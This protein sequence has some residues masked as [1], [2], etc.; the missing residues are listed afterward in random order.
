MRSQSL[1]INEYNI[2]LFLPRLGY[3]KRVDVFLLPLPE[4]IGSA[5]ILF[6]EKSMSER[7]DR[8]FNQRGSAR[9]ITGLASMLA[10]EIKNPLS[11]IRGAAQL[12]ENS[13]ND[14]DRQLTQLIQNETDRIVGL[15]DR[16]EIFSDE[17]PI[18]HSPINMHTVL[19]H[20]KMLAQNGFAKNIRFIEKYDPSLPP[21]SGHR[22]Q[23]IQIFLNLVKNASEALKN[24]ADATIILK[25][26]YKSGIWIASHN[27]REKVALPLEFCVEDNGSG[28]LAD[29]QPN[30]FDPF[31]TSKVNG[32]GLGL[33]MVAKL[34]HNHGGI[35]ECET[36]KGKTVFRV[37][38]PMWQKKRRQNPTSGE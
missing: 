6:H 21:V 38:L 17:R 31:I 34:V 9:S 29:I 20:V 36:Q 10:H 5:I 22:D 8:Q 2:D 37:L 3:N 4:K 23:L 18:E 26:S 14:E 24:H 12:I 33:P 19:N 7:M 15:V 27:R 11:G 1:P 25:S 16:M 32:S 13:L 35:V 28:I 30:L